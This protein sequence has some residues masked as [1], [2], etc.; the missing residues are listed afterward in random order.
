MGGVEFDI[1]R[2]VTLVAGA[3]YCWYWNRVD[4]GRGLLWQLAATV[5]LG[6]TPC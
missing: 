1:L 5:L 2:R 6:R 4:S 3:G